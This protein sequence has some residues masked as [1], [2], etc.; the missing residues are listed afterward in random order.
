[1][2]RVF[3]CFQWNKNASVPQHSGKKPFFNPERIAAD[4]I[5]T[6]PGIHCYST[7]NSEEP[8]IF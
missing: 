2:L 4:S 8:S 3:R 5:T 6:P 1:M 7:E